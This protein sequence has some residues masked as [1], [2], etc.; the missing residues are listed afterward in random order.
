MISGCNAYEQELT[1]KFCIT[2][3]QNYQYAKR[4]LASQQLTYKLLKQ[5]LYNGDTKL[6]VH[7]AHN[8]ASIQTKHPNKSEYY[9]A[10]IFKD[11]RQFSQNGHHRL[12]LVIMPTY[13]P[14]RH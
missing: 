4:T 14:H 6:P 3:T 1:N 5:V 12:K 11:G 10:G 9:G 8:T 13:T 7:L 2:V